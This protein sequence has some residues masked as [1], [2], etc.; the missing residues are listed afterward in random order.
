MLQLPCMLV[1][2]FVCANRTRDRGCSKHPVF[3]APSVLKGGKRRCKP[4][5]ISAARSRSRIRVGWVSR[6]R[7]PILRDCMT[8]RE[9]SPL[10]KGEATACER[11]GLPKKQAASPSGQAVAFCDAA[12]PSAWPLLTGNGIWASF[13]VLVPLVAYKL[14]SPLFALCKNTREDTCAV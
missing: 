3:P 13:S 9:L 12:K 1:C 4:R 14:L 8:R 7:N 11:T 10:S 5:A 6:K 2:S